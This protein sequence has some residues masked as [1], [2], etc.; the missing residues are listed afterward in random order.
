MCFL[1]G[2]CM[3]G[4]GGRTVKKICIL[5]GLLLALSLL[6]LLAAGALVLWCLP[7]TIPAHYG[8]S[9]AVDRWGSKY[10]AL[11]LPGLTLL[12]G[13]FFLSWSF[14]GRKVKGG[15]RAFSLT[16][17]LGTVTLAALD[18]LCAFVLYTAWAGVEK[19]PGVG[20]RLPLAGLGLLLA[21]LGAL[22]P[23]VKRNPWFGVRTRWTLESDLVWEK[24]QRLG[25]KLL[26]G[27]GV[28]TAGAALLLPPLWAVA[29]ALAGCLA[30]AAVSIAYAR[31]LGLEEQGRSQQEE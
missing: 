1:P 15:E 9:G 5:R 8:P 23:R 10:E 2:G 4:Q 26:A 31:R 20:L 17:C 12:L 14:W 30:A 16:L 25:G 6:P 29:A 3:M 18:G 11:L 28:V 27:A 13:A 21:V 22:M 19:L 24:T 7:E